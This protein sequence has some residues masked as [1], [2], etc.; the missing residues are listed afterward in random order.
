[1]YV[2]GV[3]LNDYIDFKKDK[4][5]R[6]TRPLPSN[7]ISKRN[8]VYLS[9][10]SFLSALIFALYTGITGILITITILILIIIYN[11][12]SKERIL[13]PLNMGLIRSLNILLGSSMSFSILSLQ[14]FDSKIF[15]II[16]FEFL[17][18]FLITLLSR[19]ETENYYSNVRFHLVFSPIYIM[20]FSIIFLIFI[21]IFKID[22]II[23]I[24]IF[25]IVIIYLHLSFQ[26]NKFPIQK[27]ISILIIL[28]V[29][30]DS[31]FI[32]DSI[33]I[34]YGLMILILTPLMIFLSKKMYMT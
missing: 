2:G 8:A 18:I 31:I 17:Y 5:E 23:N 16:L 13:G 15:I 33:G 27:L 19:N 4:H 26:K 32:T 25:T 11:L 24:I 34:L 7:K 6:P 3:V 1:L 9:I 10:F 30:F 14:L 21:G 29:P 22:S 12:Y 28:M 20:I